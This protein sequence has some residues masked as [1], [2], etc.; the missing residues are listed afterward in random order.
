MKR[1]NTLIK[2]MV[3]F[4]LILL[5]VEVWGTPHLSFNSN[6][7]GNHDIYIMDLNG[8][9][10]Q[11][12][13]DHPA[14][15]TEITWSPNGRSFAFVSTRDGNR[16][17]YIMSV[18]LRLVRRMTKHPAHDRSPAWSPD[19]NW[20][21]FQS[22]RTKEHHIYKIDINGENLQK[23][24]TQ[25]NNYNPAWS[26]D[27]K[28][29]AFYSDQIKRGD[30]YVMEADGNRIQQ[31][32]NQHAGGPNAP[33]WSPDGEKIAYQISLQ[34][35]GIYTMNADGTNS[36]RLSPNRIWSYNPA[37]S[38]DGKWIAYDAI[39]EN[40]WG[41]PNVDRNIFIVSVNGRA[42]QNITQ[43][44]GINSNPAWVPEEYFDVRP[45]AYSKTTLWGNIKLVE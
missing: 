30:V 14:E 25:G 31:I 41:N 40:P 27:G 35:S 11:N 15:D 34:G 3:L 4:N 24:T 18:G 37:W 16:D 45:T 2:M 39:I 21:A 28:L 36:Q 44:P 43:H 19:G 1:I 32:R 9:N 6:R 7:T 29:I 20:I 8:K 13:T 17:I 33:A 23:L 12:L 10:L 26:P 38:L 22:Y 42:P 5:T